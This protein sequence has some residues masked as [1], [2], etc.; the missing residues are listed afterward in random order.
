MVLSQNNRYRE[1]WELL[2]LVVT[3]YASIEI[4][5]RI[6]F[7]PANDRLRYFSDILFTILFSIDIV[8]NFFA[9][10]R[11]KGKEIFSRKRIALN[12]LRG[13]FWFDLLAAFPFFLFSDESWVEITTF[14][15][16]LRL[17]KMGR[18]LKVTKIAELSKHWQTHHMLN[19]SLLRI[20][21][22]LF[23]ISLVTHWISCGWILLRPK[24]EGLSNADAYSLALY[25]AIT[26][27]TTV[28][29]GDITPKT[30]WERYYTIAVMIV[31]VGS[32]GYIIGNVASFLA[33]MDIVKA[34]Y[35]K[36]LEEI[37]AF[38]NYRAIPPALQKQ[39]QDYY[40]YLWESRLGNDEKTLLEEIP[41]PLRTDI[42][43]HMRKDLIKKVSFFQKG[44][45]SLLRDIVLSLS[46]RVYLPN[47]Y[48]IR[49]GDPGT[50]MFIISTGTVEVISED[51][52]SVYATLGEGSFVG[53]MALVLDQPRTASVVTRTYCDVYILEKSDLD[54]VLLRHPRFASHLREMVAE[55]QR[56]HG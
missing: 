42:A 37:T 10:Y 44:E 53:E 27:L 45:E 33:N 12:Y 31:G 4:P 7:P 26:T 14:M 41:E 49:K 11:E 3:V 6:A 52:Q 47:T 24:E 21:F 20:V 13:W 5:L 32:F 23:I 17:I 28:G 19:P 2:I 50:F 38:L 30:L 16:A 15:R 35:R 39:V 40:E 34:N 56:N 46:P 51:E 1:I 29:Y 43:M 54:I 18:V 9:T 22:F 55:R 25:W 8:V 48:I 36:K